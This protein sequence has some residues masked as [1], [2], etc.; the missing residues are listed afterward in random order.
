METHNEADDVTKIIEKIHNKA[1][2][3]VENGL[4]GIK[5]YSS[6][7]IGKIDYKLDN[8]DSRIDCITSQL[9]ELI[10]KEQKNMEI[11]RISEVTIKLSNEDIKIFSSILEFA[12]RFLST[13]EKGFNYEYSKEYQQTVRGMIVRLFDEAC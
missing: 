3:I 11:E 13:Y 6:F 12:R 5:P 1:R 7:D 2:Y 10:N 9:L 4:Q 8:I